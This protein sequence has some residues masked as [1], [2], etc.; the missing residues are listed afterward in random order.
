MIIES[1]VGLVLMI[2]GGGEKSVD[3]TSAIIKGIK[4]V[5][6]IQEQKADELNAT[7]REDNTVLGGQK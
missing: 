4:Q 2:S 5:N 1:L 6:K 3:P 7:I